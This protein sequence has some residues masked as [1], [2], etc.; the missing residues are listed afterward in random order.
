MRAPGT[1]APA[2]GPR[3]IAGSARSGTTWLADTL[4]AANG[5]GTVFEPLNGDTVPAARAIQ[6]RLLL[7]G[8]AAPDA[9]AF[10]STLFAGGLR[11]PW[12]LG[13]VYPT[14]LLPGRGVSWHDALAHGRAALRHYWQHG[15]STSGEWVYKLIR[16][17]L[18]LDWLAQRFG[19]RIVLVIRHP[20][21]VVASRLR[22]GWPW[23][24]SLRASLDD[25]R[26]RALLGAPVCR[27]FDA[28]QDPVAGHAA[29][30]AV[31]H[32][33]ALREGTPSAFQVF[34]YEDLTGSLEAEWTR[35]TQALGFVHVPSP[36]L[37]AAPSQQADATRAGTRAVS[38]PARWRAHLGAADMDRLR[39]IL[40]VSG[41]DRLYTVE[42]DAPGPAAD[43]YRAA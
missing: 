26:V 23:Q 37:R 11:T 2:D 12:T 31:Q 30:W 3:I 27:A 18:M 33:I 40:A 36:A 20:G 10:F 35:L 4:A 29:V 8:D 34:F 6:H 38:T 42:E 24:P 39:A 14:Q 41:L 1:T 17:N 28:V 19:A 7:P 5:A 16:A 43:V 22:R 15:R 21:A 13:R 25:A 9:D 32:L